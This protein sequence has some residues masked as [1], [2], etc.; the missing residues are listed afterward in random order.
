VCAFNEGATDVG[1]QTLIAI[2]RKQL[3]DFLVDRRPVAVRVGRSTHVALS[4]LRW[5]RNT[6]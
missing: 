4:S 1:D 2:V 5:I 6:E 3:G